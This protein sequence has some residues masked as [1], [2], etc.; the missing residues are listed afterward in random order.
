MLMASNLF[1]AGQKHQSSIG[2]TVLCTRVSDSS[3]KIK[4]KY[5]FSPFVRKKKNSSIGYSSKNTKKN[6]ETKKEIKLR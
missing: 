5:F 6:D 2:I 4:L 3:V 1:D